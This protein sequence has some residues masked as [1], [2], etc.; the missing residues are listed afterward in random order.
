[1]APTRPAPKPRV[2]TS[3]IQQRSLDRAATVDM[4]TVVAATVQEAA[5]A[6]EEASDPAILGETTAT[7]ADNGVVEGPDSDRSNQCDTGAG[8]NDKGN[9][10]YL[11]RRMHAGECVATGAFANLTAADYTKPPRPGLSFPLPGLL[12]LP[13][14]NRARGH[15][16]GYALGGSN[17]DTRNFVPMYQT[18]N[19]RMFKKAESIVL[20]SIQK[21]GSQFVQ[22]IPVYGD[23]N[24]A[25]P[26]K[27]KF[28]S[29]GSATVR[30]EFDNNAA[31]THKCW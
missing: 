13:K 28:F 27:I 25:I 7:V 22:V 15:L 1:P 31:A 30:C 12:D 21:G 9:I 3:R 26:T 14:L 18:A 8:F 29:F 24:S 6:P 5:L 20:N 17:K 11:P 19:D 23:P 16:I 2:D 10:V 4:S